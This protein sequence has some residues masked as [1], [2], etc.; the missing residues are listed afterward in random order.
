MLLFAA[1][2]GVNS[3]KIFPVYKIVLQNTPRGYII[4]SVQNKSKKVGKWV[5]GKGRADERADRTG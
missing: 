1:P 5:N 3:D 2:R 4:S